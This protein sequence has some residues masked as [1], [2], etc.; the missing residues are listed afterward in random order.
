MAFFI[1]PC[2][3]PD[4]HHNRKAS[5]A[6]MPWGMVSVGIISTTFLVNGLTCLA[7]RIMFLLFG[8]KI[9]TYRKEPVPRL[10]GYL[11]A[12]V[13]SLSAV[14]NGVTPKLVKTSSRPSPRT[15]AMVA[16]SVAVVLSFCAAT[17][18]RCCS[19]IFRMRPGGWC[20]TPVAQ[21]M[22]LPGV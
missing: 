19:S 20:P 17:K 16:T 7:V 4:W 12:G 15:T 9:I 13:H 3:F 11:S 2:S 18:S 14:N 1:R 6:A 21:W 5:K 8:F 22:I 10:S